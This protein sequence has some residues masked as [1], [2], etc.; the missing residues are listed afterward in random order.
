MKMRLC[1]AW[2]LALGFSAF[3]LATETPSVPMPLAETAR[4]SDGLTLRY[5]RY[6]RPGG[7]PVLLIHG[8]AQNDRGWD[9][10]IARHSF[11]R[12]LSRQGYD[13][14]IGNLRGAGTPQY[15]SDE[16]TGGPSHAWTIEDH[17]IE[18]APALIDQVRVRT[19]RR[20]F[21]IAHSM[22]AWVMEGYLA[23]LEWKARGSREVSSNP[24]LGVW[25]EAGIAGLVT[26]AGVY[27]MRWPKRL[28]SALRD[29]IRSER[30][31]YDS[32]YELE[33]LVKATPIEPILR[34]ME[35]VRVGWIRDVLYWPLDRVPVIGSILNHVYGELQM[36]LARL[37]IF[38]IFYYPP[39]ADAETVR[40][41]LRDG[42]EDMGAPLLFQ[43]AE[44]I[45]SGSTG[46]G[47]VRPRIGLPILFV[48]GD[49]DRL[50]HHRTIYEEGFLKTA[51][52][53]KQYLE[54][55]AFGHLDILNGREAPEKVF[56]PVIEWIRARE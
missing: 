20:P 34:R 48:A 9:S 39:S 29:P 46:Y 50:A 38:S 41:H 7:Q 22:A 5:K 55:R 30:D 12:T 14:W 35:V 44:V 49:H 54:A 10:P 23:G 17:A 37:P 1:I 26:I 13:V 21:I 33:A 53:D 28:S 47:G 32:N 36:Q 42:L 11:A 3:A 8:L 19:G 18:D 4:T 16:P 24:D 2:A 31:F 52:H 56:A 45:R 51:S 27:G 6:P 43:F 25:R 15:R 40:Q